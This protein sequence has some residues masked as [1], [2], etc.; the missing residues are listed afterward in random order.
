V[1]MGRL[2]TC[3]RGGGVSRLNWY[4]RNRS[5]QLS[6][7][8]KRALWDVSCTSFDRIVLH[9]CPFSNHDSSS[10]LSFCRRVGKGGGVEGSDS[11]WINPKFT[12]PIAVATGGRIVFWRRG[13]RNVHRCT[14][15]RPRGAS[16][17]R[18]RSM[19]QQVVVN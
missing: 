6:G 19:T 12:H 17:G 2:A 15:V 9:L 4:S 13:G 7:A 16:L 18:H 11:A 14:K 3:P 5:I 1:S 8:S 10:F